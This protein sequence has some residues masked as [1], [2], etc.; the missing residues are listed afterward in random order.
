MNAR[1]SSNRLSELLRRERHAMAAFLVALADF[2]AKRLWLEL[3]YPSLFTYLNRELGLSKSA[4]FYRK[5]AAELIQR[6]PELVE[7]L[8]DG[9]LCLSTVGELAQVLTPENRDQVIPRFLHL[10]KQEARS[11]VAELKP[12]ERPPRR[13]VVT[14]VR[15]AA[16]APPSARDPEPAAALELGALATAR[17]IAPGSPAELVDA[18]VDTRTVNAPVSRT[19]PP[20]FEPLTAELR[21]MHLTVTKRL[22]AKVA[23]AKEALSH[24]HPGASTEVILEAAL[25]LLLDRAEKRKGLVE[26]PRREKRPSRPDHIPAEVKR[27]V[28]VRDD[29]CCRWA[30]ENGGTCG[31][32]HRLQYDHIQPKALGGKS[33]I[34][35]VRL[36][37]ARHNLL[38]ARK[39]FGDAWMDSYAPARKA[40]AATGRRDAGSAGACAE[41]PAAALTGP[42]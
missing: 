14:T 30:L 20:T 24:S 40:T 29:G 8:E 25:D 11:V 26:K 39:I 16:A 2:D 23:A 37:C 42:T 28:W 21:R 1:D 31:S 36:L 22:E 35:N 4:A 15:L 33:T 9:K 18:K 13:E 12:V 17:V 41:V 34:E 5:T 19:T 32:R 10:S 27:A 38:A 7:P 3:G 6:F